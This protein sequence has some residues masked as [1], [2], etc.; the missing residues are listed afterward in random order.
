M[1]SPFTQAGRAI[2]IWLCMLVLIGV[3][4]LVTGAYYVHLQ[5]HESKSPST[6]LLVI[7]PGQSFNH[8]AQALKDRGLLNETYSIR[9]WALWTG[10]STK[11]KAGQYRID[12]ENS[13]AEILDHV[14]SGK[15]A[16][17]SIQFI[18]G[19]TFKQM[20]TAI[21]NHADLIHLTTGKSDE[22]V[23][24]LLNLSHTHP[25][26][27]FFPDTYRFPKGS[28]DLD[29]LAQANKIMES[30]LAEQWEARDPETPLTNP[31]EAL[32]LASIIEK[33]TG[34]GSERKEISGVFT[35][36]L[37]INMRL[38]TDPT[39][40][41]GMGDKYKGNIKRKH[42]REDTPYNTY[43]RYGLPPTPIALPGKDSII[44]ALNPSTTKSFYFVGKGDGT[45]YF[46]ENLQQ[47]NAAVRKY[48]LKQ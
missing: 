43:T 14:V 37:R 23:L 25:E 44:A 38:Q 46:S 30:I 6:E 1:N 16:L 48:Q 40:I 26:G 15:V 24:S 11:I 41:Y 33:E 18:E 27:I 3:I 7:K 32:I 5:I 2:W 17:F 35:N 4:T 22:E 28:T 39:V 8:F 9:A 20:R 13:I 42:L 34:Q 29:I 10:Q 36:R 47:H 21:A 45:H 19:W 31:Y 12:N